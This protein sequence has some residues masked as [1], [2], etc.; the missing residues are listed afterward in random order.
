MPSKTKKFIGFMVAGLAAAMATVG[1]MGLPLVM[2]PTS[3]AGANRAV[4]LYKVPAPDFSLQSPSQKRVSLH[5]FRGRTVVVSFVNPACRQQCPP[6]AAV[7]RKTQQLTGAAAERVVWLGIS[8]NPL[9]HPSLNSAGSV[10]WVPLSGGPAT[11]WS[12]WQ[13]YQIDVSVIHGQ[14]AFTAANYVIDGQGRETALTITRTDVPVDQQ[15]HT[16][17]DAVLKATS[18]A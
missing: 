5:Q 14:I 12:V 3:Q 18:G 4:P 6:S 1:A 8:V 10:P 7:I 2:S 13:A 16:L 9:T 15:A 11:L 17:A